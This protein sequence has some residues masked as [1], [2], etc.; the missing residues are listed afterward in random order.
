[1]IEANGA[2]AQSVRVPDCHSG[3]RGFESRRPRSFGRHVDNSG[4]GIAGAIASR[5]LEGGSPSKRRLTSRRSQRPAQRLR[6]VSGAVAQLGERLNG[7]Q[8]VR[9]SIPLGSIRG[10]ERCEAPVAQLDRASDFGSEGREFESLRAHSR[11]TVGYQSGQ[12]EQTV[13]LPA[14]AYVGSNPTPTMKHRGRSITQLPRV[15]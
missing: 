10:G 8:E 11:G 3:G 1:M 9:G 2:V 5:E 15:G 7:I 6:G 12:M 14:Y 13:N 4:V